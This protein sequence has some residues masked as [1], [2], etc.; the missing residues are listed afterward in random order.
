M[1]AK[2]TYS[3]EFKRDAI[4]LVETSGNKLSEIEKE[5]SVEPGIG[6]WL[7]LSCS[8]FCR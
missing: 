6:T 8:S 4:H 3:D 1:Q 7:A 2:K 5:L